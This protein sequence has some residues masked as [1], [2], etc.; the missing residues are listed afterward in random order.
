MSL[1]RT[2]IFQTGLPS[3]LTRRHQNP[4]V[5]GIGQTGLQQITDSLDTPPGTR[6]TTQR[7]IVLLSSPDFTSAPVTTLPQ[8]AVVIA[9]SFPNVPG[10]TPWIQ[11]STVAS[12]G[13]PAVSGYIS[14]PSLNLEV[15]KLTGPLGGGNFPG[16]APP[17]P[18]G[19]GSPGTPALPPGFVPPQAG[20]ETGP[21]PPQ[22]QMTPAQ[23]GADLV[24]PIAIGVG[25]VGIGALL[26]YAFT[27]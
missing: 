7:S 9:L 27:R 24:T 20:P 5:A 11:V 3:P 8:G 19:Q 17:P 21:Q 6:L 4:G 26:W 14:N 22:G 10:I 2:P 25:A 15:T 23:P 16:V 1:F 13:R 12:L 18:P